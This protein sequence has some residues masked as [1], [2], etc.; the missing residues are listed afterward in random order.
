M[1]RIIV[2]GA[3]GVGSYFGAVL[4]SQNDVLLI[5]RSPHVKAV[6]SKGL[7]L[8]GS[9]EGV[10]KVKAAEEIEEIPAQ[11]LIILTTKV[12]DVEKALAG[13]K[14]KLRTDTTIL[15]LQNGLGNEEIVRRTAGNAVRIVRGLVTSGLEFREPGRIEV[16]IEAETVLEKSELGEQ[17]ARLFKE[18]GLVVRICEDIN[19]E[20]WRK[21]IMNCVVN[22]LTAIL[23][24]PDKEIGSSELRTVRRAIVEECVEV[25]G[26]EHINVRTDILED[27]ERLLPSYT[28]FSSMYQDIA[29]GNRTE[30][31]FLNGKIVDL[32]KKHGIRT[33]VNGTI[34]S[35]IKYLEGR[36]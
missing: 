3:G 25:A 13:I 6:N 16:K 9:R 5:A 27:L 32:A 1:Q 18:S 15:I 21:L 30:I 23:R 22:P 36:K 11:S 29:R 35:L 4:S 8:S 26:A 2:L 19:V 12:Y 10:Y 7:I 33:P 14:D 17:I 31:D 34:V 20:I 24:A 28:N